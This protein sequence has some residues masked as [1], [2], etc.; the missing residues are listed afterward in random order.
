MRVGFVERLAGQAGSD[1]A[2][3]VGALQDV[4]VRTAQG[5]LDGLVGDL[6]FGD[7]VVEGGELAPSE[8]PPLVWRS[9]PCGQERL[10]LGELP[11]SPT[12]DSG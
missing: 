12:A 10:L 9:R 11:T 2:A 4:L 7:L 6:G 1:E 8:P 3:E 5:V